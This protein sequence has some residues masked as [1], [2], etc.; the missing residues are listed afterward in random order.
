MSGVLST[1]YVCAQC[2]REIEPADSSHYG[3]EYCDVNGEKI[4]FECMH[5]WAVEHRKECKNEYL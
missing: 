1:K 2:G 3:E 5:D 4:H